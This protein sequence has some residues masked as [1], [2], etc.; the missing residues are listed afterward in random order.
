[1]YLRTILAGT[2][3]ALLIVIALMVMGWYLETRF[4]SMVT[5]MTFGGLLAVVLVLVGFKLASSNTKHTLDIT[6]DFLH[7]IKAGDKNQ[8]G[9]I[10][11]YAK[12]DSQALKRQADLEFV[13]A[14]RVDQLAQQRARLIADTER[15]AA[16]KYV[17]DEDATADQSGGF[18][19]FD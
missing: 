14:K 16:D 13:Q 2:L 12:A 11:E 5:V 7:E 17:W 19:I 6:A 3:L 10:R 8:W 18:E 9:V 4:G 1:M 15:R